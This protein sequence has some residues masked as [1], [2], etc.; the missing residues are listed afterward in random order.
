MS[1]LYTVDT[2][3]VNHVLMKSSYT[4]QKPESIIYYLNQIMG[5]GLLVV[6]EDAHKQQV[7]FPFGNLSP[8]V[9]TVLSAE[10]YGNIHSFT[11]SC[12]VFLRPHQNPAFGA[13][14]VR[15]LTEIIVEKSIQ[16]RIHF[17]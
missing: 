3:A 7:H 5:N 9:L 13:A 10:S 6:E 2:K 15:E 4:Y 8:I 11:T 1:R 12:F 16:V 14:Q 17:I